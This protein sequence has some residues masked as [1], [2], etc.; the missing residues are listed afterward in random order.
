MVWANR[1][2]ALQILA[3]RP[4]EYWRSN[5]DTY[6]YLTE[7]VIA[8]GTRFLRAVQDPAFPWEQQVVAG[9]TFR[10]RPDGSLAEGEI[11][12]GPTGAERGERPDP[13]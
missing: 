13:R 1:R 4:P 6:Q 12:D 3:S 10:F 8:R 7:H 5:P 9:R 2:N 11:V